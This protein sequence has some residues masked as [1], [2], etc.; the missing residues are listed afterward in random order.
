MTDLVERLQAAM[1]GE[2]EVHS[3]DAMSDAKAE[4]ERLRANADSLWQ[5]VQSADEANK[6]LCADNAR[7]RTLVKELA[8][9]LDGYSRGFRVASLRHYQPDLDVVQRARAL[10]QKP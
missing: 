6:E 2:S 10:V 4:I 8:D 9:E 1:D 7:L 5:D 3:F